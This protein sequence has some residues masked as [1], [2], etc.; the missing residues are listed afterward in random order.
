MAGL[1]IFEE[2]IEVD[3]LVW[4]IYIFLLFEWLDFAVR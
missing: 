4:I 1:R 2:L 3:Y